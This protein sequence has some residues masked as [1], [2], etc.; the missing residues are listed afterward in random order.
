M[1]EKRGI[2]AVDWVNALRQG[3]ATWTTDPYCAVGARPELGLAV[4]E[5]HNTDG[6]GACRIQGVLGT[7]IHRAWY[8]AF[9]A[10]LDALSGESRPRN[11]ET[12]LGWSRPA[13][14]PKPDDAAA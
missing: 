4:I 3:I 8:Q 7:V 9:T 13:V 5:D 2:F 6:T 14:S 12:R 11:Q 1:L 10:A